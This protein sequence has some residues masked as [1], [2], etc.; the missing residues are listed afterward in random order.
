MPPSAEALRT[1]HIPSVDVALID[2]GRVAW[3]RTFGRAAQL[4]CGTFML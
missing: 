1:L 4:F 2:N 3:S